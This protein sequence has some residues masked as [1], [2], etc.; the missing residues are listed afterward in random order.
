MPTPISSGQ[1]QKMADHLLIL[2][3]YVAQVLIDESPLGIPEQ[4]DLASRM[5]DFM[6]IGRSIGCSQSTLVRILYKDCFE[7]A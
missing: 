3:S 1:Q 6:E 5:V 2:R 4:R 7:N